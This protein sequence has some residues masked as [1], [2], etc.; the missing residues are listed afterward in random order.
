[1]STYRTLIVLQPTTF[2][3]IDCRY[4]YLPDRL[5]TNRMSLDVVR[6]IASEVLSSDLVEAPVAFL[7]HLGEPLAAPLTFYEAAF[8]EIDRINRDYQREYIHSFQTNATLLNEQWIDLIKKHQIRVGIS[9]DG[10]A[11]IHDR[12]R[13]TR[14]GKGTHAAVLRGIG[15]L[16]AADLPFSI[17]TVLTDF[18]LDYPDEFFQFLLDRG[19]NDVGFNIDEIEGI[20]ATT[21][22][23]D[24][25][26][27]QR[28]QSFLARLTDLTERQQGTVK[29]R[30]VWTNLRTLALGST[31]PYNTTNQPRRILN[32][33][34]AGNFST[35]CPELVAAKSDKYGD[36][37]M[38]NIL[39]N[40]LA[41]LEQN[42]VFQKV[43]QEIEAG[44]NACKA[45]CSYWNFCGGG[46]PSNKFFEHGRFDVTETTTCRV[47]KQATVDFLVN[48]LETK[49]TANQPL[50]AGLEMTEDRRID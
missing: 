42:P 16:Q 32:F 36:F 5:Q 9:L 11:F 34:A 13:I 40:S 49:L 2:C 17:I 3:N 44:I 41:D 50:P 22:F 15:L 48:Y 29:I 7:W 45:S 35:F 23:S 4:C 47:H 26:S 38:G 27:V 28:Y 43:H 24:N 14:N 30:E 39:K 37:I 8:A 10:P 19:I 18:T 31:E 21:S 20:H 1:M 12:Q 25:S 33:D 6:R 46:S